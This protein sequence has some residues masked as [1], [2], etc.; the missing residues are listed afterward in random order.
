MI[1]VDPRSIIDIS[2]SLRA[3]IIGYK[4]TMISLSPRSIIYIFMTLCADIVGY[5]P[6]KHVQTP[7]R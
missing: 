4:H 5:V 7:Q 3:C 1:S 2:M 6:P